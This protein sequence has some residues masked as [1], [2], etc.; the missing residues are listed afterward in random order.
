MSAVPK[1]V[2]WHWAV[3]H[4]VVPVHIINVP[5]LIV[6]FSIIRNLPTVAPDHVFE[7]WVKE[8]DPAV[9][10]RDEYRLIP[11]RIQVGSLRHTV[12]GNTYSS[13]HSN[14]VSTVGVED[15]ILPCVRQIRIVG[16]RLLL[17]HHQV[18][19][20]DVFDLIDFLQFQSHGDGGLLADA[21]HNVSVQKEKLLHLPDR[22]CERL[23]QGVLVRVDDV[24]AL[25]SASACTVSSFFSRSLLCRLIGLHCHHFLI[26][27]IFWVHSCADKTLI[28]CCA[29][30]LE[31]LC[32]LVFDFRLFPDDQS[33][34]RLAQK[35][36]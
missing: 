20:R 1:V 7:V 26:R 13:T 14:I 23:Q 5:I 8:I 18:I 9:R 30:P 3:I 32:P 19:K 4:K 21:L 10:Y 28:F 6:V 33:S 25:P 27:R 29:L 12:T 31:T 15:I 24:G 34:L 22:I 35:F 11:K 17:R 2:V 36:L 16:P